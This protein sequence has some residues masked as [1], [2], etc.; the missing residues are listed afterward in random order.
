MT[1]RLKL[2]SIHQGPRPWRRHRIIRHSKKAPKLEADGYPVTTTVRGEARP[3][4]NAANFLTRWV[5]ALILLSLVWRRFPDQ[6]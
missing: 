3:A 4:F 1:G 5:V 2:Q 6:A